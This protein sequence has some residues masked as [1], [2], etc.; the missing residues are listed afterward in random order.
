MKIVISQNVMSVV[1]EYSL[2]DL[3]RV[4]KFRPEALKLYTDDKHT[5]LDFVIKTGFEGSVGKLG[6]VFADEAVGTHKAVISETVPQGFETSDDIKEY[7]REEVGLSVVKGTAV[8]AQ[9]TAAMDEISADEAA[10]DACITGLPED[11]E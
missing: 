11:A 9:I 6:L 4:E 3:E 10:I 5:D 2:A 8:E 7:V 1:S